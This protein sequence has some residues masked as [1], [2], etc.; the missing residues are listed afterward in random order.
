[1]NLINKKNKDK[2]KILD[3]IDKQ[4]LMNTKNKN[5]NICENIDNNNI[6]SIEFL[7]TA[8]KE[9]FDKIYSGFMLDENSYFFHCG[10]LNRKYYFMSNNNFDKV[11]TNENSYLEK[12]T[13]KENLVEKIIINNDE[14][15][16]LYPNNS[17]LDVGQRLYN[18]RLYLKNKLEN[19]RRIQINNIKRAANLKISSKSQNNSRNEIKTSER[20]YKNQNNKKS[21]KDKNGNNCDS[22]N[23]SYH[24]KI[25]KKSLLIAQ[26]LEPSFIRLNKKKIKNIKEVDQKKYY[27][28]LYGYSLFDNTTTQD[29][30]Q[31]IFS[32]K[33][34]NNSKKKDNNKNIFD[35]INILYLKGIE[36]QQK[37]QKI[38]DENQKKK[39]DEY[40]KYPFKPHLKKQN[41]FKI[42]EKMN[43][44]KNKKKN[45]SKNNIYNIYKKQIEWKK[46]I[47]NKII[48]NKEKKEEEM[49][50]LCTFKPEISKCNYKSNDKFI[51]KIIDQMNEYV[52]KRRKNIECKISEEKN[53]YRKLYGGGEDFSIKF[54]IPKEFEF[55]TETRNKDLNKNK[56]RSCENFHLKKYLIE[57]N[58]DKNSIK[59]K[60]NWFFRK[61]INNYNHNSRNYNK[62]DEA[63]LQFN[64]F[65]AVNILHDK[66]ENLNI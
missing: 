35:K 9:K 54:T 1:M 27:L 50:K 14:K 36:E 49:I 65:E 16:E 62:V 40:K 48:K 11:P 19:Q 42:N 45:N 41:I 25:N 66:L 46:K 7:K 60:D 34:K 8:S 56:N 33:N 58:S 32:I 61:D 3:D 57:Q 38:Y 28:N 22:T 53:K 64:F 23:F 47:E 63:Q 59:N 51:K 2:L 55:E 18:Y 5:N 24:P 6:N 44:S 37:K 15:G 43:S 17:T 26:K 39:E 29:I 10:G 21:N 30:S 20:L 4:Y 52:V 12:D 13:K 31:G